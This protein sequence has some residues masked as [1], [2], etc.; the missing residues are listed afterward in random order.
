MSIDTLLHEPE[1]RPFLPLLYVAWADGD[2]DDDNRAVIRAR[3]AQRPWLKPR[4]RVALEQWLTNT[5]PPDAVSLARMRTAIV[6]V[7]QTLSP[8]ARQSFAAI[9][10]SIGD[11]TGAIDD[12]TRAA[13]DELERDL[14]VVPQTLLVQVEQPI[15]PSSSSSSTAASFSPARLQAVLDGRFA[16]TRD[17]VRAFL[18][19]P[20]HRAMYG[21][22]KE[23]YREQVFSWLQELAQAGFG[24]LAYPGV[25]VDKETGLGPF[26]VSFETLGYG[27]LSLV[28]KYGVQ[29]GLWG[30]SVF[31][32]GSPQQQQQYLPKVATVESP[33]CF[34]MSEVGH[35]SNVADLETIVRWHS[36]S[37]SFRLHTPSESARKDWAGN[38]AQHAKFATVFAQLEVGDE[39]HGVHAFVVPIRDERGVTLPGIRIGDCGHKL[40]LNGVDNGRLWFDNVTLPREALLGRYANVDENGVYS[41][42]IES[43]NKRFFTMLGTLVGGRLGVAASG[44]SAA[45]VGLT[46]AL[47]YATA[48][49]QF[50]ATS[51]PET[52]LLD[53]PSHQRRLLPALA[54]TYA[55]HFALDQ[56][57]E[58][59]LAQKPDDDTRELEAEVAGIK[60]ATTWHVSDTLQACREACGGQGYLSVNRIADARA[61]TDIFT[62][63]E[64]D[65]TVLMQLLAKGLLT[66]FRQ[67]FAEQGVVRFAAR[68]LRG[69]VAL[70]NPIARRDIDE[71]TLRSATQQ[72]RLFEFREATL[73]YSAARRVQ[74]RMA[75]KVDQT[76]AFSEVQEHLLALAAA[77][78]DTVSL[79]AFIA[80]VD[81][82][83][84]DE[85]VVLDRLR[86]LHGLTLMERHAGW[87]YENG[88][89]EPARG[90]AIRKLVPRI[91]TELLP[92]V[93]AL[94]TSF[95]IPDACLAA[96][97]AFHD[98]AH[99]RW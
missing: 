21:V 95:G 32:L 27:D 22:D 73:L 50:G 47:R 48:R 11:S 57:R 1:L 35:G 24:K 31:F 53:Y 58:T 68:H 84:G 38:A 82:A 8:Q 72:V 62:T 20:A 6:D 87:F 43:P 61:D 88:V 34:A 5:T 18:A 77:H 7:A 93:L 37:G 13:I 52:L 39:R 4:I 69:Q 55:F 12:D 15:V 80:G 79:R 42:P 41:S 45:K 33:G 10:A 44:L 16:E 29:F 81:K 90:R 78:V 75:K 60:A 59:F 96:P 83:R 65:N 51:T 85:R 28:V 66:G 98:P 97:I 23:R 54:A 19:D 2:L 64:G 56:V 67:R 91:F 25:T 36:D 63:F 17:S 99:P 46:V 14:G 30:G 86:Q 49:R 71:L 3:I 74:Q 70:T 26:L 40:G 76:L 9:A 94:T 89:F 92:D